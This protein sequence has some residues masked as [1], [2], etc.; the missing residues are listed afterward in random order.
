[1]PF[2]ARQGFLGA[3]AIL[4]WDTIRAPQVDF[5]L[6]YNGEATGP[7]KIFDNEQP[8][9]QL[10]QTEYYAVASL[11]LA[12]TKQDDAPY[13]YDQGDTK[14]DSSGGTLCWI[15]YDGPNFL[16]DR[17]T[18]GAPNMALTSYGTATLAKSV[19]A[20][21]GPKDGKVYAFPF[22]DNYVRIY[23]PATDSVE[24]QDWGIDMSGAGTYAVS[25][26]TTTGKIYAFGGTADHVLILD[27]VAN[28]AVTS[29]FSGLYDTSNTSGKYTTA[30]LGTDDKIYSP[31]N[32]GADVGWL[33]IDTVTNT[34]EIQDWSGAAT[35][36]H[37]SACLGMDGNIWA[38]P[39][40]TDDT[41]T[42]IDPSSNT[43]SNV[44]QTSTFTANGCDGCVSHPN[45]NIYVCDGQSIF[46][47]NPAD[48]TTTE[49]RNLADQTY[50]SPTVKSR[51][52]WGLDINQANVEIYFTPQLL[53]QG[54]T[55]GATL[56][57]DGA[58]TQS[59]HYYNWSAMAISPY[60]NKK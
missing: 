26:A 51:I 42:T 52:G 6:K 1:M 11:L 16:F 35:P 53:A 4:D 38:A 3:G 31:N 8:P 29:N 58:L 18:T 23:D 5:Y 47:F 15:P 56:S 41:W 40:G 14:L 22:D 7:V 49:L 28:T 37:K 20:S 9:D 17:Q 60:F 19:T 59:K 43:A 34:A 10:Q 12:D 33:V 48:Y 24:T 2:S 32:N 46:E 39:G 45:G 50:T 54:A 25:Q 44:A 55:G 21:L 13:G 36:S 27:T 57:S 30:V